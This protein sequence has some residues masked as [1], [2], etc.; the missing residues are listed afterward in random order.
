M[1]P[2]HYTGDL[3]FIPVTV[4]KYWQV[5]FGGIEIGDRS[6]RN[7]A[8]AIIDTG[9]TLTILPPNLAK[10]FH[11]AI[12]G[13]TF[14]N[15]YGWQVPCK[16]ASNLGN[17][18]FYLGGEAFPVPIVD[19]IRERSSPEDPSLCFSGVAA[20]NSNLIIM[21]D[22]FLRNYYS[23]YDYKQARIGLAPSKA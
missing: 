15:R 16:P 12:P 21:G 9:T 14:D 13:A 6:I 7:N 17:I 4:K 23:V 1:N 18:T 2:D 5:A 8:Q 10:A 22:T 19:M 11:D 20:A 3:K